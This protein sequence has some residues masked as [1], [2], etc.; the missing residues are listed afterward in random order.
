MF[1]LNRHSFCF[2]FLRDERTQKVEWTVTLAACLRSH[3]SSF[4]TL[5]EF[6]WHICSAMFSV[7]LW[8]V[9]FSLTHTARDGNTLGWQKVRETGFEIVHSW[10][11][12]FMFKLRLVCSVYVLYFI[13]APLICTSPCVS[14]EKQTK[15]NF[16][17]IYDICKLKRP[18]LFLDFTVIFIN[19][20]FTLTVN[21]S[22]RGESASVR[23]YSC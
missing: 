6:R 10:F 20:P 12:R 7:T 5:M 17:L 19:P 1:I 21:S 3:F 15:A 16:Y 23:T 11:H 14:H 13:C 9:S 18:I 22:A 8:K 4:N 2:P